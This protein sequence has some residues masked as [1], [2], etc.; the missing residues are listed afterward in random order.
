M[1]IHIPNKNDLL[2]QNGF[3]ADTQ[4]LGG[5]GGMNLF[6]LGDSGD[7]SWPDFRDALDDELRSSLDRSFWPAIHQACAKSIRARRLASTHT[8]LRSPRDGRHYMPMLSRAE[9]TGNNSATFHITFVQVAAGTQSEV[10]DKGVAR[11]FTAL[12]LAHRFRWEVIDP[13]RDLPR[14]QEFVERGGANGRGGLA[15]IWEAI[16]LIETEAQN[17]GVQDEDALPGDFGPAACEEVRA[18]FPLWR[19]K[20]Q[21]LEDAVQMQDVVTFARVLDELDPVNIRFISLAAHRLG[22]L[23]QGG[24]DAGSPRCAL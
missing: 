13:Y 18:M 8:V 5:S 9:I 6:D 7:F 19:D 24:A 22:E 14:L 4:I 15:A 21:Q 3:P 16:G 20:R 23:V 12:N 11:I 17:R 1:I 2:E 10:R